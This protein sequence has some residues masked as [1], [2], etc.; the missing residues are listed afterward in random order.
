MRGYI[1]L[2]HKC[3]FSLTESHATD[4]GPGRKAGA[5]VPALEDLGADEV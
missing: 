3:V 5:E 4:A 1:R 2:G